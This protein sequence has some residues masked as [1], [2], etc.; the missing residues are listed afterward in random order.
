[1]HISRVA[2]VEEA[3][4]GEEVPLDGADDE[5]LAGLGVEL[6][7]FVAGISNK[8][9]SERC[10]NVLEIPARSELGQTR[11]KSSCRRSSDVIACSYAAIGVNICSENTD[12]VSEFGEGV[13]EG[14]ED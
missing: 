3:G 14:D 8:N 11:T 12:F 1:M 10:L 4:V 6:G 7:E 5:G 2:G 13:D 9:A